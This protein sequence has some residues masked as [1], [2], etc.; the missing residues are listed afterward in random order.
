MNTLIR[1]PNWVGDT[2]LALP[3]LSALAHSSQH[4]SVYSGT[5]LPLIL[6]NH[7]QPD[8]KRIQLRRG[9]EGGLTAWEEIQAYRRE[10]FDRALILT[11]AFSAALRVWCAGIAARI[12]WAEQGR[13]WLLNSPVR[14]QRRGEIHIV[15]EFNQLAAACGDAHI[16]PAPYLP[17]QAEAV[18]A[19][20]EFLTCSFDSETNRPL[21]VLCPGANYGSAKQ[22]PVGHFIS[23]RKMLSE[24]GYRGIV[25]G[26]PGEIA[27]CQQIVN[28]ANRE[29]INAAGAGD[30]LFSAEL[31]RRSALAVCNDTGTM[32]LAAAVGT[33]QVALFGSTEPL[34]TGPAAANATVLRQKFECAPCFCK[35]CPI[36][37]PAPCL[38][39][40]TPE[41][42]LEALENRLRLTPPTGGPA[43]FIDR[44]GTLCELVPYLSDP[45]EAVLIPGAAAALARA[46]EA[47]YQIVVISNQSGVARGYFKH[48]AVRDVNR[49]LD[50]QLSANGAAV[51]R[52]YYCPHHPDLTG[53]CTCRKPEP[54]LIIQAATEMRLDLSR[55]V[56][57]GDTVEDLIA[58]KAAGTKS[59][60]VQT[61][62]GA[63][64]ATERISE[65]PQD[66]QQAEDLQAA[67]DG[68]LRSN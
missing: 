46:K 52:F 29:W 26:A 16:P 6:T 31:L 41:S 38:A 8:A 4:R 55:S 54:G 17:P 14:R 36:D 18:K 58:G 39:A 61:G 12:G 11:P 5:Q 56:M 33:P 30:I 15:D 34:W 57:I 68:I 37:D 19:A 10:R 43:I 27:L 49:A 2:I 35:Q 3:A 63:A 9:N 53:S 62:Y 67:I 59:I 7:L 60:L 65:L 25:T 48:Q 64:Q 20:A 51:D 47:G 13:G 23:L 1:L 44:D 42:V 22:W 32:H 21:I 28:G 50:R 24:R 40:I 66:S 45:T